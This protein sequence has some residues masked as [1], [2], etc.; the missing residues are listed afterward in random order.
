MQIPK[1]IKVGTKTYAVIQVKKARTKNTLAAIDYQHGIIWM[2][3]HDEQGIKLG[4]EEMADTFWHELTHA[5]LHD[6]GHELCYDE[7]FVTAFANRLSLSVTS[8]QL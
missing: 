3:T 5:V 4:K 7:K 1:K 6:M 8:A 2:A